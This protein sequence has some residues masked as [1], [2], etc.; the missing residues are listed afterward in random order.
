VNIAGSALWTAGGIRVNTASGTQSSPTACADSQ[1]GVIVAWSDA[2]NGA[3]N[4]YAQRFSPA[5]ARLWNSGVRVAISA[6][7]EAYASACPDGSGGAIVTWHDSRMYNRPWAQRV[8][9]DG[10]LAWGNAGIQ[11]VSNVF[12][13]SSAYPRLLS[14]NA[15]GAIIAWQGMKSGGVWS[16]TV[17]QIIAQRIDHNGT[18]L[19]GADATLVTDEP[20]AHDYPSLCTDG[21]NGAIITWSWEQNNTAN[22]TDFNTIGA[23]RLNGAGA[24]QWARRASTSAR[25][26]VSAC[27]APT[28]SRFSTSIIGIRASPPT[29]RAARSSHGAR[30]ATTTR[31]SGTTRTG[32]SASTPRAGCCGTSAAR[33]AW[34]RCSAATIA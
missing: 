14:D 25:R 1:G 13:K 2:R 20:Q 31:R 5:G 21:G 15:G 6:A 8:A 23:Q 12:T 24:R 10:T 9:S 32:C 29:A 27:S 28:A 17:Q 33:R 18:L 7:D 11:L 4:I 16:P 22:R 34:R 19:W 3:M 30:R 26:P